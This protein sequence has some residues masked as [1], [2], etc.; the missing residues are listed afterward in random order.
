MHHDSDQFHQI[1][2]PF[3]QKS[4]FWTLFPQWVCSLATTPPQTAS[5]PLPI[6]GM[7]PSKAPTRRRHA[8]RVLR[9]AQNP[10]HSRLKCAASPTRPAQG[11]LVRKTRPTPPLQQHFRE[12]IRPARHKTPILSHLSHAGRTFSR[13]HPPSDRAGRT[14]SRTGHSHVATMQ[15]MTPLRP[16]M[17]A[18]AKPPS[19][20]LAPNKGPLKPTSPLHPKTAPKPPISHPQRRWR[21]QLRLDLRPQ[22]RWRFQTAR[23]PGRQGLAAVPVGGGA[24]PGFETTRRATHQRP[25][26]TGVEGAGGTGGH[27]RA[28]RRGA[29]RSEDA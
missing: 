4:R 8:V 2:D 27:G 21:F 15:P 7:T 5:S 6:G 25:G 11:Q 12:R 14:F 26:P 19:P 18:S 9:M 1:A 20:M 24:W 13:S 22:R 23:P 28:S 10:H 16:L 3:S 29:E 17:Q